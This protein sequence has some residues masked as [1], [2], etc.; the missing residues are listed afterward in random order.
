[1]F[2][3][4]HLIQ[5]LFSEGLFEALREVVVHVELAA[6]VTRW[7]VLSPTEL[8]A[9]L[10][11]PLTIPEIW[12]GAIGQIPNRHIGTTAVQHGAIDQNARVG[13]AHE[14]ADVFDRCSGFFTSAQ[15]LGKD[16]EVGRDR[17]PLSLCFCLRQ[18]LMK[19]LRSL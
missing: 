3:A 15:L 14:A 11:P 2:F 1:V 4:D 10:V 6:L 5:A 18:P 16:R 19:E 12:K 17:E 9:N 8:R 13:I 7:E